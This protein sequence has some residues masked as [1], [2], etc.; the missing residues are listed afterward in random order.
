MAIARAV[1]EATMKI[2]LIKGGQKEFT[3]E[4][5]AIA[6]FDVEQEI[7]NMLLPPSK[8][9]SKR[10]VRLHIGNQK[11][12]TIGDYKDKDLA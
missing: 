10:Y 2:T 7:N 12:K 8:K 4:D 1:Y 11:E 5:L 9:G 3:E 6:M